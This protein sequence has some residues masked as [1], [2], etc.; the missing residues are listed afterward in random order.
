MCN[1]DIDKPNAL[2]KHFHSV[3]SKPKRN[4]ALFDVVSHFESI[5]SLSIDAC[6]VL[7]QLRRLNNDKE[8]GLDELYP[9]LLKLVAEKLTPT[10]TIIFQHFYNLNSCHTYLQKRFKI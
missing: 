6:G 7:S 3:L 5:S 9:Q 1:S 10:L 8:N 2:N 4:I